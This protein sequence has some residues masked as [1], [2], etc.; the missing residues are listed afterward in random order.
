MNNEHQAQ[1][2]IPEAETQKNKRNSQKCESG[3]S[4]PEV[5]R[6]ELSRPSEW[7]CTSDTKKII[8]TEWKDKQGNLIAH[9]EAH[10]YKDE[11][12]NTVLQKLIVK[13]PE[14]KKEV[15]LFE[16]IGLTEV[17]CIIKRDAGSY[18][19]N[20]DLTDAAINEMDPRDKGGKPGFVIAPPPETILD[21]A[22]LLH[23]YGHAAQK[24]NDEWKDRY[25]GNNFIPFG[26][27]KLL[28]W[29]SAIS[30][31]SMFIT[32]KEI[33]FPYLETL[34]ELRKKNDELRIETNTLHKKYAVYT[35]I[36][37]KNLTL[38][39]QEQSELNKKFENEFRLLI[40][41]YYK[42]FWEAA[43]TYRQRME[44]DAT[45]RALTWIRKLKKELGINLLVDFP[46]T[47]EIAIENIYPQNDCLPQAKNTQ[48]ALRGALEDYKA[49]SQKMH[50]RKKRPTQK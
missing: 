23:E 3:F 33:S 36:G 10:L 38:F 28:A 18:S 22:F 6:S 46:D 9:V 26:S 25:T 50:G 44:R 37:G 16:Y 14:A 15:S 34:I 45:A 2:L 12:E 42:E 49:T 40:E 7:E 21:I 29:Q 48:E 39:Y 24:A 30:R 32:K 13:N 17:K 20:E 8:K 5:T 35:N 1:P 4:S 47:P 43:N 27:Y 41:P 19:F 11:E 31:I